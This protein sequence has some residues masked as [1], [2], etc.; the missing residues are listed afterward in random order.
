MPESTRNLLPVKRNV[1]PDNVYVHLTCTHTGKNFRKS[2][3]GG[4]TVT[5]CRCALETFTIYANPVPGY[6]SVEV[7]LT[8]QFDSTRA[9]L[10]EEFTLELDE[11]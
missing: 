7:Y 4:E 3:D 5:T 10:A 2:L 6:L 1:N 11:S 8:D 9:L